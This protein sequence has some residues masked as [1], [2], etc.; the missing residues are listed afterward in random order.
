LPDALLTQFA[1]YIWI[2]DGGTVSVAGFRYPTRM[3]VMRLSDGGL[4]VWSPVALT[5]ALRAVVDAIGVVRFIVAPNSLHHLYVGEWQS[6]YPA[7]RVLAAPGLTMRRPDLR[8]DGELG[9]APDAAWAGEIDQVLMRSAITTEAVFFHRASGTALFTDLIQHFPA[10]WFK[11]WRAVV[12]R[13]DRMTGDEPAV[14][15]KFRLS[16]TDRGAARAALSR[17]LAWPVECVLMAHG[18]PVTSGA[19]AFLARA[20]AWLQR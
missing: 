15:Q 12:A 1:A 4:F 2:A 16:F 19:Q 3:A 8:I 9:D 20:F 11:G 10:G 5:D 7:A 14:P 18:A 13:L 17:I 6:A